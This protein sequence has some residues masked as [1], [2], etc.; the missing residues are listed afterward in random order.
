MNSIHIY[1]K[2]TISFLILIVK[3]KKVMELK[4]NRIK[5][6]KNISRKFS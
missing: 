5:F 4:D 3:D 6:L 2:N 1:N